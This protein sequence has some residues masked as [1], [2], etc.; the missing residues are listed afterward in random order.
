MVKGRRVRAWLTSFGIS[1]IPTSTLWW[2]PWANL[3]YI[4]DALLFEEVLSA[5]A[6]QHIPCRCQSSKVRLKILWILCAPRLLFSACS[7][8]RTC[9]IPIQLAAMPWG[10]TVAEMRASG[11]GEKWA[12]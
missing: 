1:I 10:L 7:C 12:M 9:A 5:S 6:Q 8:P 2:Q 3:R 11:A 4:P